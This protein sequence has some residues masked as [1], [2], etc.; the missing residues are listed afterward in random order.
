M[1]YLARVLVDLGQSPTE[2]RESAEALGSLPIP[3]CT[4][5]SVSERVSA[6]DRGRTRPGPELPPSLRRLGVRPIY[7]FERDALYEISNS[8]IHAL[9]HLGWTAGIAEL[10]VYVKVRSW[11]SRLYLLA[12]SPFRHAIVYPSLIRGV[13]RKWRAA[14]ATGFTGPGRQVEHP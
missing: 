14:R 3:G 11:V 10:A 1:G 7:V 8:T 5:V 12:I 6:E 2:A 9:L 4:E 13:S